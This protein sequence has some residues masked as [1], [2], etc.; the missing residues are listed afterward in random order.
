MSVDEAELAGVV[1]AHSWERIPEDQEGEGK[2]CRKAKSGG[3]REDLSEDQIR[4]VEE[5]V[6]D[7][8]DELGY[9][10]SFV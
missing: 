6:G 10:R 2:F 4:V 8:M 1:D 5:Q 7:P 3:W 9:E